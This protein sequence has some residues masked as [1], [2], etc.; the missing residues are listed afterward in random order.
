M[1]LED[2]DSVASP[3]MPEFLVVLLKLSAISVMT[4]WCFFLI[5]DTL[6]IN[7]HSRSNRM[8]GWVNLP[9]RWTLGAVNPPLKKWLLKDLFYLQPFFYSLSITAV[10]LTRF[11]TPVVLQYLLFWNLV[12]WGT[13]P[14]ETHT[15][16]HRCVQI[17]QEMI[18]IW[19]CLPFR[20]KLTSSLIFFATGD[21][22]SNDRGPR[23]G[24]SYSS[25]IVPT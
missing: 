2:V 21:F 16:T 10:C 6:F 20:G 22:S 19:F 15:H 23:L 12:V 11:K 17:C 7:L 13:H 18:L 8:K 9:S 3:A 1:D 4:P 14:S 24:S 25:V 5:L